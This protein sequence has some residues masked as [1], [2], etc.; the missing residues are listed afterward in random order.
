MISDRHILTERQFGDLFA[1][2]LDE[3]S[4][5]YTSTF[6]DEL[7]VHIYNRRSDKSI[8]FLGNAYR[9]YQTSPEKLSEIIDDQV[10]LVVRGFELEGP[11]GDVL[12]PVIRAFPMFTCDNPKALDLNEQGIAH[13]TISQ[14]IGIFFVASNEGQMVYLQNKDL[15]SRN[16]S[17]NELLEE[18]LRL[19]LMAKPDATIQ[20]EDGFA[21]IEGDVYATSLLL[22]DHFWKSI[23]VGFRGRPVVYPVSRALFIITGDEEKMGMEKSSKLAKKLF[24]E[25][26]YPISANPI[27]SEGKQWR[28][29]DQ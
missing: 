7:V 11:V 3:S 5:D 22:L 19:L 18:A 24:E 27:V 15:A 13:I 9:D 23:S 4:T 1:E 26:S 17:L 6:P 21:V 10:R 12:L 29:L 16:L 14:E 20:M 8:T 25:L 28:A 2:K